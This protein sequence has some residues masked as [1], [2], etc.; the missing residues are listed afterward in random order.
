[1]ERCS[2]NGI[3]EEAL[4]AIEERFGSRFEWEAFGEESLGSVF[5]ER[6]P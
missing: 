6:N 4:T 3:P 2:V 5:S 1:M